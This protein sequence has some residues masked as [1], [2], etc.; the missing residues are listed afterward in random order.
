MTITFS[1]TVKW[2]LRQSKAEQDSIDAAHARRWKDV[3]RVKWPDCDTTLT[4]HYNPFRLKSV[5]V[6]KAVD[7]AWE[8]NHGN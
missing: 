3:P 6:E 5:D 8:K 7:A 1:E 2:L 4:Y